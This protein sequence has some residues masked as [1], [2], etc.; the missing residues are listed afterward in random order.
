MGKHAVF[1]PSAAERWFA[2]AASIKATENL[3]EEESSPYAR[4]GSCAHE[5]L[6]CVLNGDE[7]DDFIGKEFHGVEVT[8]DMVGYVRES[9]DYILAR[10]GDHSACF[11]ETRVDFSDYVPGG[12]GTADYIQVDDS[13]LTVIDFKYGMGVAVFAPHNKQLMLYAL[14]AYLAMSDWYGIEEI[15]LVILQPRMGHLSSTWSLSVSDLLL[16][17]EHAKRQAELALTDNPPFGPG[18]EACRWCRIKAV[19]D[20]RA[21]F[22]VAAAGEGYD[23]LGP[24][25]PIAPHAIELE[26]LTKLLTSFTGLANWMNDVKAYAEERALANQPVPGFKLVEGRSN[27]RWLTDQA[28]ITIFKRL[29]LKKAD[30]ITE[31]IIG[32]TAAEKLLGKKKFAESMD[33]A[34]TKPRGK[35]ALVP[36]SDPRPVYTEVSVDDFDNYE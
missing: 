24:G 36:E 5:V 20:A 29:R 35:P 9:A 8:G 15:E 32:I 19:C 7:P 6:A 22:C 12:S 3:P 28:A 4:E 21:Q 27:R 10:Q 11:V 2:C 26:T 30:Y 13:K 1:A 33:G 31:S 34:V 16:F 14:G 25:S 17:A 18:E 23:L